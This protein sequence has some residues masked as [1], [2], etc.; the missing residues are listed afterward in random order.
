M[1]KII[2]LLLVMIGFYQVNA[3]IWLDAG[4]KGGY[5]IALMNNQ[6]IFDD[7]TYSH[8]ISG[9]YNVGFK[10]GINF[11]RVSGLTGELLF[12]QMKQNF[13][14]TIDSEDF[15]NDIKWS[16]I[17]YY[18]LYRASLTGA[19]IELGPMISNIRAV[20][21]TDT[22][23][24]LNDASVASFYTD[25]Y[26]SGVFGVGGYLAGNDTFTVMVGLR[27]HY[28]FQDMINEA[29]M[30]NNYPATRVK[31]PYS[32]YTETNP[33]FVEFMVEFNWGIGHFAKRTCGGRTKFI[34]GTGY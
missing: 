21:Q 12:S 14:Y 6:N 22:G 16:N 19:Y 25:Q 8:T 24:D 23:T 18:I 13:N 28:A 3:Q 4:V 2:F 20:N 27:A 32:S 34:G 17:D 10:A 5:G 11:G 9:S 1:K 15:I 29:G 31:N 33:I 30:V 26:L 7:N